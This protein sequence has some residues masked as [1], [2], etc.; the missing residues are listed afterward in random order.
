M[1]QRFPEACERAH[2]CC[3]RNDRKTSR[4]SV[5]ARRHHTLGRV[6]ASRPDLRTRAVELYE[7]IC[8]VLE[9]LHQEDEKN[10]ASLLASITS[11][12]FVFAML[13]LDKVLAKTIIVARE[14]QCPSQDLHRA[15]SSIGTVTK[16]LE[17]MR[18]D[19]DLFNDLFNRSAALL[20]H[21]PQ[22]PRGMSSMRQQHRTN[23]PCE[24]SE[25]FFCRSIFYPLFDHW[26]LQLRTRFSTHQEKVLS[27][28]ALIPSQ[29]IHSEFSAIEPAATFY[30][31][32]LD[33]GREELKSQFE[34]FKSIFTG[35]SQDSLP[36][37]VEEAYKTSLR[38]PGCPDIQRLL[39][40]F[41]TLPV[42][43][44]SAERSFRALKYVKNYL[45][46][47]MKEDRLN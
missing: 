45:R 31:R 41:L 30:A 13:L 12:R 28:V 42:T 38:R 24:N 16:Q 29:T 27:L 22:P 43:S 19:D 5:E 35:M 23:V 33:C 14:L 34:Y 3:R 47:S 36:T 6:A 37:T 17:Q 11:D 9:R 21:D 20:G 2:K 15:I 4:P 7:C 10:A 25:Q 8:A 1:V 40:I 26:T 39:K 32:L 44:A 18:D 46:S